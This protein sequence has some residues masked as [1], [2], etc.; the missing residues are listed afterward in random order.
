MDILLS[1]LLVLLLGIPAGIWIKRE[2]EWDEKYCTLAEQYRD[3]KKE[4]DELLAEEHDPCLP[5]FDD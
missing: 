2:I 4:Y 1:I 5:V 3:L